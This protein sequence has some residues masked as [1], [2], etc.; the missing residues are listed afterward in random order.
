MDRYYDIKSAIN[1]SEDKPGSSV[2]LVLEEDSSLEAVVTEAEEL[3]HWVNYTSENND[4]YD[5]CDTYDMWG[6]EVDPESGDTGYPD[7]DKMDWRITVK[8]PVTGRKPT[9]LDS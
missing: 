4:P 9:L 2:V 8:I 5:S 1:H 6:I 3:G 7:T